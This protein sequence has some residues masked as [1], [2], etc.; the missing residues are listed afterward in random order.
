MLR[1]KRKTFLIDRIKNVLVV[2][3]GWPDSNRRSSAPKADAITKLRYIPSALYCG[4]IP[5]GWQ[6]K[7]E[8]KVLISAPESQEARFITPLLRHFIVFWRE[9]VVLEEGDTAISPH[10]SVHSVS[11]REQFFEIPKIVFPK[12]RR[13]NDNTVYPWAVLN[14]LHMLKK[15]KHIHILIL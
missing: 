1:F 3:S 14:S 5:R 4:Q 6:A 2:W 13:K 8:P 7:E 10:F 11:G 12:T 15:H 9:I